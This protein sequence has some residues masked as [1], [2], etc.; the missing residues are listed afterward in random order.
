MKQYFLRDL[1][2]M[3]IKDDL[4]D[5]E[6]DCLGIVH[7]PQQANKVRNLASQCG[8]MIIEPHEYRY[9]FD[10]PDNYQLPSTII[11]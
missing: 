3:G 4:I 8:F 1:I 5:L 6:G 10:L 11:F 2:R 9:S 7:T